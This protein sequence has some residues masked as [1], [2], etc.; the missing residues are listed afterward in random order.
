MTHRVISS[1]LALLIAA[2]GLRCGPDFLAGVPCDVDDH[3][4]DD[5][6]CVDGLCDPEPPPRPCLTHH[7]CP[8][9]QHCDPETTVCVDGPKPPYR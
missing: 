3:C 4:P 1:V 5:M 6:Y 7:D 2:C 9:Q 8:S